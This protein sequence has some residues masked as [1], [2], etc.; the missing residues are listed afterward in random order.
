MEDNWVHRAMYMRCKTCM[1]FV[2]K[3]P[4]D[5]VP[6]RI[7]RCRRHAPTMKGWPAV[8]ETDWC[9]DHKID[10]T[11]LRGPFIVDKSTGEVTEVK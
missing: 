1:Y 9:G 7:G 8:F 2:R 11:K 4:T 6:S 3:I 10:E 5:G